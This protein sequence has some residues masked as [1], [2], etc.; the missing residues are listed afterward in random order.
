MQAHHAYN[1][2]I[3]SSME[4]AA[5]LTHPMANLVSNKVL[6]TS[7]REM[8]EYASQLIVSDADCLRTFQEQAG[9]DAATD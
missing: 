4:H 7:Q 1:N 3:T 8:D 2:Q 9:C 6:P 5:M